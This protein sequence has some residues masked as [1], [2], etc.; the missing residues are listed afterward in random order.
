MEITIYTKKDCH[1]CEEL[2]VFLNRHGIQ[3]VEKDVERPEVAQELLKSEYI[4]KNF[5]DDKGCIVIT[6]IVNLDG[7]WMHKEFFDIR[8]FSERRAKKIFGLEKN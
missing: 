8:G 5:C 2:K 6:P 4:V 1:R 7:K 3:Y